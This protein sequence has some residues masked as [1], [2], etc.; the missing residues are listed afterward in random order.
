MS[1]NLEAK[2]LIVEEIKQKISESKSIAFVDYRGLNVEKDTSLRRA[3]KANGSEYKVYKNRLMLIA[4][5]ELGITGCDEL[6]QGTNA[7]VFSY[8]DEVT[9]PKVLV[10]AI[11]KDKILELKFGIVDNKV[12]TKAEIEALATLPSKEVLLGKLL[13]ILNSPATSLARVLSAPTTGFVRALS[14]IAKKG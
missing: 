3:F 6:L 10:D 1:A 13:S 8:A 4:L 11:K 7:V 9:A 5:N 14:E 2:K 12:V